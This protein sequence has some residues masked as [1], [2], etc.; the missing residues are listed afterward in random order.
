M[1][2]A[3]MLEHGV[4]PELLLG[5]RYGRA[6]H[7]W[8]LRTRRHEQAIDLG[9]EHQMVLAL[10]PA[11]NPTR[12]YGFVGVVL[13]LVDLSA[14]VFLWYLARRADGSTRRVEGPQGH[15]DPGKAGGPRRGFRP[16]S[17][18][19]ASCRRSSRTSIS[20]RTIAGST[21]R[22]GGPASCGSTT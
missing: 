12:A 9:S 10:C 3:D 17:A 22:A 8:D 16:C 18:T 15:H 7:V 19:V 5:G 11:H 1:G 21:C 4:S 6:L 13:S 20:R 14:S 2:H